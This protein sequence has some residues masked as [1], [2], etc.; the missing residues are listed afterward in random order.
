[1]KHK[2]MAERQGFEPWVPLRAHRI[3]SAAHST[4]L[5]PLLLMGR[6][7]GKPPGSSFESAKLI[8]TF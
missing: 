3:S 4:T 1:M 2:Y 7:C 6:R 8:L 5:A